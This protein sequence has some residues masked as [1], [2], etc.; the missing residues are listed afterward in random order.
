MVHLPFVLSVQFDWEDGNRLWNPTNELKMSVRSHL[1]RMNVSYCPMFGRIFALDF[2]RIDGTNLLSSNIIDLFPRK[3]HLSG[4][5]SV[6]NID[7]PNFVMTL[8]FY[9]SHQHNNASKH[10]TS[11][12]PS[13]NYWSQKAWYI[14]QARKKS[15]RAEIQEA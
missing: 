8:Q 15:R 11:S 2:V 7:G 6:L 12:V 1:Q 4:F 3:V 10:I 5:M 14:T 9:W 13:L